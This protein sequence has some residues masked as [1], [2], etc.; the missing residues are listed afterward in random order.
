MVL[1]IF[2]NVTSP[3]ACH[4]RARQEVA[5]SVDE[6]LSL[7]SAKYA[8]KSYMGP[9]PEFDVKKEYGPFAC[10]AVRVRFGGWGVRTI[11]P[12]SAL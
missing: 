6:F 4:A 12:V 10:G 3:H 5:E 2:D 7:A 9:A 8:I 1:S 11:A